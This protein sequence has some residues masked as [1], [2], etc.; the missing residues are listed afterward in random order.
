MKYANIMKVFSILA[1][2]L[3]FGCENRFSEQEANYQIMTTNEGSIYRLN[4]KTGQVA[5][6]KGDKIVPLKVSEDKGGEQPQKD[7]PQQPDSISDAEQTQ[8]LVSEKVAKKMQLWHE[9][10]FS[11][12]NLKGV[13]KTRWEDDKLYYSFEVYPYS[14]LKRMLDKKDDDIYYQRKWHGFIVKLLD[15]KGTVVKQIP[16]KLWEMAR[17]FDKNGKYASVL[18]KGDLDLTGL[19]YERI[20]DYNV[21]W[22]LDRV[23]I[24]DYK[25]RDK[26][27]DLIK[28]YDCYGEVDPNID[29]CA[30]LGAKYWWMTFPER[31]KVY[32]STEEELLKSY[33]KTTQ[34]IIEELR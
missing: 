14:S 1:L 24:P 27:D 16:I 17:T 10:Q 32:F 11:G 29:V 21:E 3:I 13:L 26:M 15:K 30:P 8:H 12:K 7:S 9:K 33:E 20:E 4:K 23:I 22:K 6:I 5:L 28:T 25:F 18:K 19:N 2:I 34:K 31:K